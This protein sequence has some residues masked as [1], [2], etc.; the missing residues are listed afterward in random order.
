MAWLGIACQLV[1]FPSLVST[2]MKK[3]HLPK[4]GLTCD[5]RVC[6]LDAT[7]IFIFFSSFSSHFGPALGTVLVVTGNT[8]LVGH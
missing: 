4:K 5:S 3:A 6:P 7:A 8:Y 2:I 1:I